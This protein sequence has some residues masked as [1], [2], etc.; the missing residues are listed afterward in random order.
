MGTPTTRHIYL[1][2]HAAS[3]LAVARV[4]KLS[5]FWEKGRGVIGRP[6]PAKGDGIW[7]PGVASVHTFFVPGKL[8]ILFLD[9]SFSTT[10]VYR[11]VAPWRPFIGARGACHT[12][13]LGPGSLGG[14][15]PSG[16]RWELR[17]AAR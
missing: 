13:E 16:E 15:W 14:N 4:L 6:A 17:A 3:G 9:S 5:G 8:D 7:L 1:L 11:S 12:I 10:A 2:V